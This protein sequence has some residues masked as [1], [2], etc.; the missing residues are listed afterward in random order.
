MNEEAAKPDA[1]LWLDFETTGIDRASS[2]PLEVGME[3][4]DVLGEQSFGSLTRIIRPASLDLL[5]MSPVAFSRCRECGAA[6]CDSERRT[7]ES[8]KPTRLRG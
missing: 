8:Q 6:G 7:Y 2:L 3:C 5:D 4:T 1:L